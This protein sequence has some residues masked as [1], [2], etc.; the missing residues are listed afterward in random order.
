[1]IDYRRLLFWLFMLIGCLYPLVRI[2]AYLCVVEQYLSC[3]SGYWFALN[4]DLHY[5]PKMYFVTFFPVLCLGLLLFRERR[6]L[7][8]AGMLALNGVALANLNIPLP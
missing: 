7:L 4:Y 1:M 5:P 2:Y 6:L 3:S 8:C